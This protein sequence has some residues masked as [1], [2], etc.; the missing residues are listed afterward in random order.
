[1][2][3]GAAAGLDD[4]DDDQVDGMTRLHLRTA[5][6]YVANRRQAEVPSALA[7]VD[8]VGTQEAWWLSHV[9]AMSRHRADFAGR[10]S[11]QN[12]VFLDRDRL[13]YLG[14]GAF[15][16]L[17]AIPG[18][19]F[20]PERWVTWSRFAVDA[21]LFC[22]IDTHVDAVIQSRETGRLLKNAR[23]VRARRHMIALGREIRRQRADGFD[24][25]VTLDANYRR[26]PAGVR[27]WRWSPHS[28]FARAG[29]DYYARRIDG[30]AVPRGSRIVAA[31]PFDIPGS[32]H[33]GFEL[34]AD[35]PRRRLT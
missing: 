23:A 10:H 31:G 13:K 30:I 33:H 35:I 8:V 21:H 16:V 12:A 2:A 15:R 26:P 25:L 17:D 34:V 32:N 24:P 14:H 3:A 28:S 18:D 22:L 1:V 20:A 11:V 7:G 27:L 5:N 19:K 29:L 4:L 6:V 9:D